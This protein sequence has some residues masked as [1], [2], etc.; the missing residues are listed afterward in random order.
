MC[1]KEYSREESNWREKQPIN[2]T[3]THL[4]LEDAQDE[5]KRRKKNKKVVNL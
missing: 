1:S 5:L 3:Y 4:G 2:W